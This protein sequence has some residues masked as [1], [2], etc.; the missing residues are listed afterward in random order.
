LPHDITFTVVSATHDAG[1]RHRYGQ[2]LKNGHAVWALLKCLCMTA[3][4]Q[5]KC[6]KATSK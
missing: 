6:W 3:L 1:A 5:P 2:V 4:P